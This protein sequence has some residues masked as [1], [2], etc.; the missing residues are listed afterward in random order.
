MAIINLTPHAI[1]VVSPTGSPVAEFPPSGQVAR[2]RQ[3]RT[4]D[5]ERNGV[6]YYQT[7]YGEVQDLPSEVAGTLLIVS[8][9]VRAAKPERLDL[10]SPGALVRGPDG[11]PVGCEGFDINV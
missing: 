6:R 1:N 3:L 11:Q 7:T 10:V 4:L 8:G 9:L 5:G 2:V